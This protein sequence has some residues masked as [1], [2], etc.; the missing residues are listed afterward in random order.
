MKRRADGPSLGDLGLV[1]GISADMFS[2]FTWLNQA[3]LTRPARIL[4]HEIEN[5]LPG[6]LALGG[7]FAF[8]QGTSR[9]QV[10]PLR[11]EE[12]K[13]L[14][15][16]FKDHVPLGL[17]QDALWGAASDVGGAVRTLSWDKLP[18]DAMAFY[19][20]FH[21]PPFDQW[22]IYLL[23]G[24][25]LHYHRKLMEQSRSAGLFS[26]ET[27]MHLVLFE[28]FNHEF[29]HHLVESTATT[30]EVILAAQGNSQPLYLRHRQAQRNNEFGQPPSCSPTSSPTR[31]KTCCID[32]EGEH[33]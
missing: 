25:L 13:V 31:S 24:P 11:A 20:P 16:R 18:A 17:T 8:A 14:K 15:E 10:R 28:V 5:D 32:S 29:F 21:F 4:D 3:Q 30:L 7:G 6:G 22:G 12:L 33:P 1:P 27:L 26:V 9:R 2:L 23:V 19:R